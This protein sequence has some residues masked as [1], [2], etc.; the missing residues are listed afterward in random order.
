MKQEDTMNYKKFQDIELSRLGLGNMRLAAV[1]PNA[2]E[3]QIDHPEAIKLIHKAF[4]EG[5]T[6]F[7]TA[8]VYNSGD[9][10][11]T[12][13]EAIQDMDRDKFYLATKWNLGANPDYKA[14]FEE[15]LKRL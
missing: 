5:I 9:S 7:D 11:V 8:Y 4:D 13:G 1:D 15:Q 6:Y 2:A 3:V 12:V 14:V 10:E